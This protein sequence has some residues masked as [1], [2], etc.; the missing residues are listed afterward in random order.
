M[1]PF[2][3]TITCN[4][5]DFKNLIWQMTDSEFDPI[6][7]GIFTP[8]E[9]MTMENIL[10]EKLMFSQEECISLSIFIMVLF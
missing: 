5:G 3:I 6:A 8:E 1:L 7:Y 9:L 4:N 2:H 10:I